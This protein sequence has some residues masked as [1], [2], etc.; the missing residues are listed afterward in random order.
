MHSLCNISD[1]QKTAMASAVCLQ[2]TNREELK[3]LLQTIKLCKIKNL[4]NM[5]V[6][7]T[8]K[9]CLSRSEKHQ[10]T[11]A[12][13]TNIPL[14]VVNKVAE[15]LSTDRLCGDAGVTGSGED[16][17]DAPVNLLGLS[18]RMLGGR[19]SNLLGFEKKLVAAA[20]EQSLLRKQRRHS[21]KKFTSEKAYDSPDREIT[22]NILSDLV[23][24]NHEVVQNHWAK[25]NQL[26]DL[27]Q[28]VLRQ[29]LPQKI[30]CLES[31]LEM[32][33]A[34]K[35]CLDAAILDI[36]LN[37]VPR[38]S[39]ALKIVYKQM[40]DDNDVLRSEIHRMKNLLVAYRELKGTRFD[41]LLLNYK[42]VLKEI[43]HTNWGLQNLK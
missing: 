38:Y 14:V 27:E 11:A 20:V 17:D 39:N 19:G 30:T 12:S 1:Q 4:R 34:Q 2:Q 22:E 37:E 24:H 21:P 3:Y 6:L 25:M 29:I 23:L 8:L 40:K 31:E 16:T 41:M 7:E 28:R 33:Q 5:V 36:I 15:L 9:E 35:R 43:E 26:L 10:G 13:Q 18:G 42:K 32:C